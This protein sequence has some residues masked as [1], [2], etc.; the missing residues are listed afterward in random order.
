[1]ALPLLALLAA[2]CG[3]SAAASWRTCAG[4]SAAI[5]VAAVSVSPDPIPAGARVVFALSGLQHPGV[6]VRSGT[7]R[8]SVKYMGFRVFS[9]SGDLCPAL[10]APGCP[11]LPG[12]VTVELVETMPGYLPPGKMVMRLE[13]TRERLQVFCVEV[14]LASGAARARAGVAAAALAKLRLG[15]GDGPSRTTI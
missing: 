12:N 13:G 1:M 8:A 10:A 6:E 7:L 9:K 4:P 11:L 3:P 15:A 14:E 5:E 2:L